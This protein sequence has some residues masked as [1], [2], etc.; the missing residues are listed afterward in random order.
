MRTLL[1]STPVALAFCPAFLRTEQSLVMNWTQFIFSYPVS[2]RHNWMLYF[3]SRYGGTRW[4]SW[5]RHCATSRKVAGSIPD[6]V[7]GIF[8]WYNPSG[9]TMALGS[10][11]PLTEMS[12]MWPVCR[13][14]NLTTCMCW[15]SWNLGASTSWNPR[16]LSRPVMGLL[17]LYILGTRQSRPLKVG[18]NMVESVRVT[19]YCGAFAWPLLQWRDNNMFSVYCYGTLHYKQ[20]NNI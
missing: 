16:G 4:S 20:Y 3:P 12:T 7:I 2:L 5:L 9:R 14:D 15:L 11:Q 10:T 8:H 1:K 6:G 13:A 19:Y 17:Y 18:D